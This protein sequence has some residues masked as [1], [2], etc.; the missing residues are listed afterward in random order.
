MDLLQLGASGFALAGSGAIREHGLT[1]RPTEDVDLF[2]TGITEADFSQAVDDG[3]RALG[4][5]SCDVT[6]VRRAPMFARLEVAASDGAVLDAVAN[7]VGALFSRAEARDFLDV[8]AIRR[9]G[10]YTDEELLELA[11]GHDP[12]FDRMVFA[13]QLARVDLL[14]A[15]R[16]AQYGVDEDEWVAVRER[17]GSW[18]RAVGAA[19]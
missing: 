2:S 4:S 3:V 9:A 1:S 6:V 16:V 12:G 18:A 14:S 11:E 10:A 7:K 5:A 8:D 19:G 15:R 13:Q 17:L